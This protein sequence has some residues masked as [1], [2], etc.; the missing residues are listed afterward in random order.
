MSENT[1]ME[2]FSGVRGVYG[3]AI[4]HELARKYAL[5]YCQLFSDKLS[6]LVIGGDSRQ[7]TPALKESMIEAFS[8]AGITTIIDVGTV[9][10][11]VAE[12]AIQKFQAQGGVYITASHNEPE[13]NGWKF[14][15]E[16]DGALLYPQQFDRLK[17]MVHNS[18][19]GNSKL[20][21]PETEIVDK[22]EQSIQQ[23]IEHVLRMVGNGGVEKVRE[24]DLKI[25]A[26]PNGGAGITVLSKLFERLGVYA[27]IINT[28]LGNFARTIEPNVESMAPIAKEMESGRF[29]FGCGFDCDSDRVELLV[30]PKSE[31][32]REMGSV[33][34]GQ[35]VLALA[36]DIQLDGTKNQVVVTNDCTSYLIRDVI[37]K[38]QAEVKEVEVGEIN[39][40]KEMEKQNSIIGG[41]GS[42]GGVVIPP[43]WCR[44]G[45]MLSALILKMIAERRKSLSQILL[46]YPRY[47]SARAKVHCSAEEV[48]ALKHRLEQYYGEKGYYIKKTGDITG[49]LKAL[50]DKNAN[51]FI[52]FRQSKSEP[53]VF[54][55]IS[56]GDDRKKV[57][58]LFQQGVEAFDKCRI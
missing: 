22:H 51:S 6:T 43:I 21:R 46:D 10:I 1:I 56:D 29:E 18:K 35:Y 26:D 50:I 57:E 39:V 40:V 38:Y 12:Y 25:L 2:S 24:T 45:I 8:S 58:D 27:K 42:N 9:P 5:C 52:W 48:P 54:R 3:E 17:E 11:P 37:K 15:K 28:E 13:Y 49:G 20:A 47:Y 16:K 53:G 41:E 14:L 33:V 7:S 36:C 19:E 31:F 44:D 32:A 4:T 30:S 34:S 55:I 23:Y